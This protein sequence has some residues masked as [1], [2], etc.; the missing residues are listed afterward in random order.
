L[1]SLDKSSVRNEVSQLKADYEQLCANEKVSSEMAALMKSLFLIIEL[2]LSIF[3]ERAT[4]KNRKNSSIPPSQTQPDPSALGQTGGHGK[5]KHENNTR[6]NNTQVK[7]TV[8]V[9]KVLCCD[10]CGEDLRDSPCLHQERRTRIDIIFEKI[11]EH[12]D[13]EVKV[14]GL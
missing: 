7:E 14:P 1:A 3:L 12:V 8:T 11:V 10:I 9:S 6:A 2:I 5:G 4:K 13:A